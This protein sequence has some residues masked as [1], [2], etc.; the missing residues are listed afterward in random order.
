MHEHRQG[1]QPQ[2]GV[3]IRNVK[4]QCCD[5]KMREECRGLLAA[6]REQYEPPID[7]VSRVRGLD[8]TGWKSR[9]ELAQLIQ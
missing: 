9:R 1:R 4:A 3:S 5:R 6:R 2:N 8:R 7:R